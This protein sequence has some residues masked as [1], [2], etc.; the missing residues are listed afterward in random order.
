MTFEAKPEATL[1]HSPMHSIDWD[2]I[3]LL[4]P[5]GITDEVLVKSIASD[6][7]KEVAK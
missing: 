4:P 3:G 1:R 2:T 6:K 7:S 5:L